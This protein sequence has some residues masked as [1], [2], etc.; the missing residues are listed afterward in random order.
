MA[1]V[2][3]PRS[4]EG[5]PESPAFSPRSI[6]A[7]LESIE[8]ILGTLTLVLG[9]PQTRSYPSWA[10][11]SFLRPQPSTPRT[12]CLA[13]RPKSIEARPWISTFILGSIEVK[14]RVPASKYLASGHSSIE[15]KHR[16]Q[17]LGPSPDGPDLGLQCLGPRLG[18]DEPRL[19]L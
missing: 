5:V 1:P 2:L 6:D 18:L 14:S 15:V 13:P 9:S 19:V 4:I 16:H 17:S 11:S 12:R 10:G 8:A 7:K 3:G